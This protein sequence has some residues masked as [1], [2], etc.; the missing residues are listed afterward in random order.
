MREEGRGKRERSGKRLG[1][2]SGEWQIPLWW[3]YATSF[4]LL[5]P[6]DGRRRLFDAVDEVSGGFFFERRHDFHARDVLSRVVAA[7]MKNTTRW[8]ARGRRNISLQDDALLARLQ[9][10]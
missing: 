7:R 4:F 9:I 8:R 2:D 6:T 1:V 5:L 10:G 3:M